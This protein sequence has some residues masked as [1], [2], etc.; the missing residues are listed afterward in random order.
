MERRRD[1]LLYC[2]WVSDY[3]SQDQSGIKIT[4]KIGRGKKDVR[5][6]KW[7]LW[8][9]LGRQF[10][11]IPDPVLIQ[12]QAELDTSAL[13]QFHYYHHLLK[14]AWLGKWW[15][16]KPSL[17]SLIFPIACYTCLPCKLTTRT[18]MPSFLRHTTQ[19]PVCTCITRL[20]YNN[21]Y[22]WIYHWVFLNHFW[23]LYMLTA[24]G[25]SF[26]PLEHALILRVLAQISLSSIVC[27]GWIQI[28]GRPITKCV[29]VGSDLTYVF[30]CF[31][32]CRQ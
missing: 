23:L 27:Q 31:F 3:N 9:C 29:S 15:L 20:H 13:P 32:T 4:P 12:V 24:Y 26:Y 17:S 2:C 25:E 8:E 14:A 28:L 22:S 6:R 16:F 5:G 7:T 19:H 10:L 21:F 1:F 18:L 30:L 11:R